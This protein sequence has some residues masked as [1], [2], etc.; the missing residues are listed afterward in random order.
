MTK[1]RSLGLTATKITDAGV[2]HLKDLRSL[3]NLKISLTGVADNGLTWLEALPNLSFLELYGTNVTD[4][5]TDR[6]KMR[7]P[8]LRLI[9]TRNF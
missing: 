5:G 9:M 6:L 4:A 8:N 2:V 1:L 7:L 3:T